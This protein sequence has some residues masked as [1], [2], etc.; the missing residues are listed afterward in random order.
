VLSGDL[1]FDIVGQELTVDQTADIHRLNI[2]PDDTDGDNIPDSMDLDELLDGTLTFAYGTP[3]FTI[4]LPFTVLYN[5]LSTGLV[6]VSGDSSGAMTI[7]ATLGIG[8][9]NLIQPDSTAATSGESGSVI[10]VNKLVGADT[11]VLVANK[12][13]VYFSRD[14]SSS[15]WELADPASTT[16]INSWY[17]E[18]AT[19]STYPDNWEDTNSV[20]RRLRGRTD[21]NF[22]W[23][24]S[25]ERFNLID[26]SQSNIIDT[27]IIPRGYYTALLD[28]LG[29]ELT[30]EPDP[31]TSLDLR[32]TYGYLLDSKMISDTVILHSGLFKL[33]FGDK[34][35][36][37]LRATFKVI[38][39]TTGKLTDNE[40]KTQIVSV[41]KTFFDIN[42]WEFGETFYYTELAAAIHND[43]NSEIDSVVIVPL[44]E[45]NQFG[46][47]FMVVAREDEILQADIGVE[48]IEVV[49]SYTS[50]ILRQ[51]I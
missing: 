35:D 33:L 7:S 49:Q 27:F 3:A 48:D 17:T 32:T 42:V 26:P 45:N 44:S 28:W 18:A 37:G 12:D 40:V 29:G 4:Q 8:E 39:P 30:V 31:P 24:H 47:M 13:Y 25:A 38:R 22:A 20:Y 14:D 15:D 9:Y 11:S 10:R 50:Q 19:N 36:S 51:D 41:I 23:F 5:D 34:A 43:L 46:D 2:L 16:L 21:F 6:V 1:L